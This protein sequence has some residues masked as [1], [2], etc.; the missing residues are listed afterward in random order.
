MLQ[1]NKLHLGCGV[2][3]PDGW[4]NVDGSWNAWLAKH[5]LLWRLAKSLRLLPNE[6]LDLSWSR[7]IIVHDVRNKLPFEDN[8]MDA[9][10]ASHLLEHLYL[11]EAK[12][13]LKECHR[14]LSPSGVLR[15]VVPDLKSIVMEYMD[16]NNNGSAMDDDYIRAD[17][18]N[19]RLL[20]RQ[21]SPVNGNLFYR[22][23]THLN[24]FHTHKWMYDAESLIY[25]FSWAGLTDV[26]EMQFNQSRIVNIN[27]IE[28][29]ER[30]LYGAGICIEGIKK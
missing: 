30:V 21:P 6:L 29:E 22:I 20:L 16:I 4:L 10:Y 1:G 17:Q 7:D 12:R 2:N 5:D 11:E 15:M 25:Y 28:L 27:K 18:L 3:T 23:Y 14:V 8:S 24:D 19:Y 9:I 26:K 13:M